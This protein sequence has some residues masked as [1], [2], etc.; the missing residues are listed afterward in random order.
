MSL[1][2]FFQIID[3]SFIGRFIDKRVGLINITD[4]EVIYVENIRSF[5]NLTTPIA[6]FFCEMAVKE[7][8]FLKMHSLDCPQCGRR[9]ISKPYEENFPSNIECD[10]CQMLEKDKYEFSN[11]EC[12][13]I[14]FYKLNV[15]INE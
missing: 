3:N 5:Y 1:I 7:N 12:Q 6:R 11:V 8:L 15:G 2:K 10:I 9:L 14:T 4:P 13:E